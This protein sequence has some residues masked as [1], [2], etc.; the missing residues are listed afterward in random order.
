MSQELL[1][2]DH[3]ITVL[4]VSRIADNKCFI[5][6]SRINL[7]KRYLT[8]IN[9]E[10]T[11]KSRWFRRV[12]FLRRDCPSGVVFLTAYEQ[13]SEEPIFYTHGNCLYIRRPKRSP[14]VPT[15]RAVKSDLAN[16]TKRVA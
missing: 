15:A 11:N 4:I 7:C 8:L 12:R 10:W 1:N 13:Y 5:E 16:D 9:T 14:P 3:V 6:H 2:P